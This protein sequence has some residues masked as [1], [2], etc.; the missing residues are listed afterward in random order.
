MTRRPDPLG[1][2]LALVRA[3]FGTGIAGSTVA[4]A[5]VG[6]DATKADLACGRCDRG[7][8]YGYSNS[9]GDTDVCLPSL[10][11]GFTRRG[12]P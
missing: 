10:R 2:K 12:L 7:F 9:R 4:C 8:Q 5:W 6:V 1:P 11:S 3:P